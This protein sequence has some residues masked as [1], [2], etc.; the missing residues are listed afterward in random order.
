ML[1]GF[2][3][4]MWRQNDRRIT[5]LVS[6]TLNKP[7]QIH[8]TK[9]SKGRIG[10]IGKLTQVNFS[11]WRMMALRSFQTWTNEPPTRLNT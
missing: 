11:L 1:D 6:T 7:R 10:L 5:S 9:V 2:E 8:A 4:G 3:L